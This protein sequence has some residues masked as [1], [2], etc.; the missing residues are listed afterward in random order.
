MAFQI[1]D[2]II[3]LVASAEVSGKDRASDLREGKQTL[4]NIMAREQGIDLTPYR[5]DLSDREIDEVIEKLERAGV[6]SAVKDVARELVAKGQQRISVLPES[7]EK[8]LL[9]EIGDFFITRRF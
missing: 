7:T 6:I 5:R 1:Q 2:D 8:A 3:D 9:I 4:I